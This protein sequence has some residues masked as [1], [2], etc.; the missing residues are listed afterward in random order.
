MKAC[1]EPYIHAL[2]ALEELNLTDA[3]MLQSHILE[4]DECA[5]LRESMSAPVDAWNTTLPS[6]SVP[7]DLREIVLATVA[8]E[9]ERE[10]TVKHTWSTLEPWWFFR[11]P[12]WSQIIPS[13]LAAC[14]IILLI[15]LVDARR[16]TS[17]IQG[18]LVH[19]ESRV[20]DL[21]DRPDLQVFNG[22]TIEKLRTEG[23]FGGARGQVAINYDTG[24]VA[25]RDIPEPPRGKVWQVWQVNDDDE[26]RSLGTISHARKARVFELNDVDE[27]SLQRIMITVEAGTGSARPR[28]D[29]TVASHDFSDA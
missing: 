20:G 15:A 14:S 12:R 10:A 5:R 22:A 8:R 6:M 9:A 27:R 13:A 4:C 2:A 1:P 25:L 17:S 23:A 28:K 29:A 18:K 7:A 16:D 21:A 3:N 11:M 24:V 19:L 26:I